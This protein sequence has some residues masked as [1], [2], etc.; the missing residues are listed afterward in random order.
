MK[1]IENFK[2]QSRI[3]KSL[4]IILIICLIYQIILITLD[5]HTNGPISIII[6]IILWIHIFKYLGW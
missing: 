3:M 2:K 5:M 6:G 1:I 4:D